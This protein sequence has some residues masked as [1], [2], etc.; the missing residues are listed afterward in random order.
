MN[1]LVVARFTKIVIFKACGVHEHFKVARVVL[2]HANIMTFAKNATKLVV[3]F[4]AVCGIIWEFGIHAVITRVGSIIVII[5]ARRN[6]SRLHE[7]G[8]D[9]K[10]LVLAGLCRSE[11]RQGRNE[12]EAPEEHDV[13]EWREGWP[14]RF[15]W[16]LN[17]QSANETWRGYLARAETKPAVSRTISCWGKLIIEDRSARWRWARGLVMI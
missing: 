12:G 16:E 9:A 7:A 11:G 14:C 17:P 15:L 13:K 4:L 6:V 3:G 8:R 5:K 2:A 10:F 1:T